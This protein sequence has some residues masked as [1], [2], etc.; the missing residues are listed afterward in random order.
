[1]TVSEMV[2]SIGAWGANKLPYS[3]TFWQ[4]E[5]LANWLFQRIGKETF[6]EFTIA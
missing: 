4:G 6:D 1:M 3:A 2:N 5:T